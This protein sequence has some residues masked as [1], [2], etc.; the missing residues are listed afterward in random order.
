MLR[1]GNGGWSGWI[2]EFGNVRAVLTNDAG[3]VY[4]RGTKTVAVTHDARWVNR[5]SFYVEHG[6][7]FVAVSAALVLLGYALLRLRGPETIASPR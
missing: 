4:F 3:S 5:L 2:D 1:D 6:D 7:W